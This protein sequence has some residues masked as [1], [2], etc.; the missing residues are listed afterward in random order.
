VIHLVEKV[1]SSLRVAV[2][3]EF[4]GSLRLEYSL[5][6]LARKALRRSQVWVTARVDVIDG[7]LCRH[8]SAQSQGQYNRS[9]HHGSLFFHAII[10]SHVSVFQR[11]STYALHYPMRREQRPHLRQTSPSADEK[12][13]CAYKSLLCSSANSFR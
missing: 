10:S 8:R 1:F 2:H 5:K 13:P 11:A 9:T 3:I 6:S 4:I 7:A 12:I